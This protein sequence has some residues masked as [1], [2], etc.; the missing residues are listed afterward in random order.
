[1]FVSFEYFANQASAFRQERWSHHSRRRTI[2]PSRL[3]MTKEMTPEERAEYEALMRQAQ[4]LQKT[5]DMMIGNA[6]GGQPSEAESQEQEAQ[7]QVSRTFSIE[8]RRFCILQSRGRST[9][10]IADSC[11]FFAGQS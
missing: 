5:F 2:A 6:F 9:S 11:L 10:H 3:F 8:Q 7:P 4:D 1:M